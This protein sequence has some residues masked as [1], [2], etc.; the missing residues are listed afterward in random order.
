MR[1]F[2]QFGL[3]DAVP[4][5]DHLKTVL[6]T[7]RADA[8]DPQDLVG[9]RQPVEHRVEVTGVRWA[10]DRFD[11]VAA[12]H[13]EARDHVPEAQQ[14]PEVGAG[15]GAATTFLVEH[16]GGAWR[17]SPHDRVAAEVHRLGGVACRHVERPGRH[18]DEV[19]DN[20]RIEPNIAGL[21]VDRATV[22]LESV[23]RR[24]GVEGQPD[25]RQDPHR[26][27]VHLVG[28]F[29][30]EHGRRRELALHRPEELAGRRRQLRR[31]SPTP[32]ASPDHAR[33]PYPQRDAIT[34]NSGDSVSGGRNDQSPGSA[35]PSD[36]TMSPAAEHNSRSSLGVKQVVQ[37]STSA[38]APPLSRTS[39][40][41]RWTP[42]SA[43]KSLPS[44][45]LAAWR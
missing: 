45:R 4:D 41:S 15:A 43:S 33:A 17:R 1:H 37:R 30:A 3:V 23:P 25:L 8:V 31:R 35:A 11:R 26:E 40:A 5:L 9:Q 10:V 7:G 22:G 42:R 44:S 12:H 20:S 38:A 13:V 36:S 32:F 39:V 14:L 19:F 21:P 28:L 27:A 2:V 6:D 24:L 18:R 34:R 16:V 29:F